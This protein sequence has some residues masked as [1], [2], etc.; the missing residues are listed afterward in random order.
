IHHFKLY[1]EGL[2]PPAGESYVG[3]ESPRGELGFFIVSDGSGKP[4]RCHER[5]PSFANLQALPA[6]ARGGLVADLIAIIASID[7]ILGEVD[8]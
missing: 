7:P 6:M 4:V 2:R 1:T 8:R 5:A 3:I